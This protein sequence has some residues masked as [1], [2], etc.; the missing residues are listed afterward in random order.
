ML[1]SDGGKLVTPIHIIS[2]P[3]SVSVIFR[4]ASTCDVTPRQ[5]QPMRVRSQFPRLC[6]GL[7]LADLKVGPDV[8]T[9]TQQMSGRESTGQCLEYLSLAE[10]YLLQHG[11]KK[12]AL[13]LSEAR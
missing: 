7:L 13:L 12:A 6:V 9:T 2:D 4:D 8:T 10:S 11:T 5:G 1:I 3:M